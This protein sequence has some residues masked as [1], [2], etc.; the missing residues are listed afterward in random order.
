VGI[1]WFFIGLAPY[2]NLIPIQ[3]LLTER[4]CYNALLGFCLMLGA[5]F[6]V[7]IK[8]AGGPLDKRLR[9]LLLAVL[10]SVF[11]SLSWAR[12]DTWK[13]NE[14]LWAHNLKYYPDSIFANI[15]YAA[16]LS[17]KG[18][19][20]RALSLL[21]QATQLVPKRSKAF[22][23]LADLQFELEQ[24]D[25]AEI[26]YE[27]ALEINSENHKA[28]AGLAQIELGRS[29]LTRAYW[30]SSKAILIEPKNE[31]GLHV[32][33]TVLAVTGRC[34][35]A[36]PILSQLLGFSKDDKLRE[37]A[38]INLLVCKKIISQESGQQ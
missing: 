29:N 17:E 16:A 32:A 34:H 37:A 26:N 38:Q 13:S 10:L 25:K 5:G 12:V 31:L 27:K 22:G 7:A 4:Y 36:I 20:K 21:E 8:N 18:Y 19:K 24:K 2:S 28:L 9:L 15:N 1:G 23:N 14:T 11:F 35:K 33:G 3:I 30:L 6:T